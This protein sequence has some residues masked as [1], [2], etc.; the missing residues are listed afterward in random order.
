M[1]RTKLF[2]RW[3]VARQV[4]WLL[5]IGVLSIGLSA[6]GSSSSSG[7]HGSTSSAV[8][9]KAGAFSKDVQVTVHNEPSTGGSLFMSVCQAGSDIATPTCG[10]TVVA[11]GAEVHLTH[12]AVAGLVKD[13]AGNGFY[14][15]AFNPSV[16]EPYFKLW[17][18]GDL[19][20]SAE[21]I[22]LSEGQTVTKYLGGRKIDL[23]RDT[24]TDVK[25]MVIK[26]LL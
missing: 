23:L 17:K 22:A 6:C 24:D 3:S 10:S 4:A 14:Y 13:G 2:S 9:K 26:V 20:S 12:E 25:V 16:G 15:Y 18:I 5:T 19:E 21:K 8:K 11:D 7:T 1:H